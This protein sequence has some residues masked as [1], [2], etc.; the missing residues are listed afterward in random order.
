[1][2][3]C[4]KLCCVFTTLGFLG[5]I[6]FLA[7][8]IL[9][10]ESPIITLE[11]P[12][13][14]LATSSMANRGQVSM[15]V[16]VLLTN[17]NFYGYSLQDL[18]FNVF[19][20]D[21]N[22]IGLIHRAARVGIPPHHQTRFGVVYKENVVNFLP[23]LLHNCMKDDPHDVPYYFEG[24]VQVRTLGFR[25]KMTIDPVVDAIE[26]PEWVQ[27]DNKELIKNDLVILV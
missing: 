23:F 11:M 19:D 26:C 15:N 10:Y 14:P 2:R 16:S 18:S 25:R 27:G 17:R 3:L 20:S 7:A 9:T 13:S 21:S 12:G 8:I 4:R 5:V 6:T 1:M 22:N 24:T